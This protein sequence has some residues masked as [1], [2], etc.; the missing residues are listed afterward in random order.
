M[1][2]HEVNIIDILVSSYGFYGSSI[3]WFI[4]ILRISIHKDHHF[5]A[6]SQ[7]FKSRT[8]IKLPFPLHSSRL[9][10]LLDVGRVSFLKEYGRQI[11]QFIKPKVNHIT[12]VEFALRL[13]KPIMRLSQAKT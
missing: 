13:T 2:E 4:S 10:Q 5:P 1:L 7:F 12:K 3:T 8:I 6:F 11:E 9:T